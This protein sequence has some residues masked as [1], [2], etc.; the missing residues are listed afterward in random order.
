MASPSIV[1]GRKGSFGSVHWAPNGGFA[2]DTAYFIDRYTSSVNLRWLYYVL[3]AIDLKGPSQDVGVPGLARDAAYAVPV[4]SPPEAETQ[5]R[6]ADF[7]DAETR[8]TDS[9]SGAMER[10]IAVLDQHRSGALD[11][12]WP[13]E[14]KERRLGYATLLVTSGSRAWAD[15]VGDDGSP[16]FRSANLRRTS[17][18]PNATGLA[19]V[20]L[21]ASVAVEARRSRIRN[22][23]VL[24]GIT[25][26]NTGWVA[27]ADGTFVGGNVSQHVCLVRPD[28]HV[29]HSRWLAHL[30]CTR[31]VQ[32]YL[33]AGQYGGTKTQ[34]SL[35]DIRDVRVPVVPIAEQLRVSIQVDKALTSIETLKGA[36]LRQLRLLAERRQAL[37]T[38]A[39]TGQIDVSTARG[40]EVP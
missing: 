1:I 36:R 15:Y 14:A 8:R 5:R 2:I 30:L 20:A 4:P 10:Q 25:G 22:G 33:L 18:K 13:N 11:A 28:A 12:I 23:D 9:A 21:P 40:V 29:L 39:V 26:A 17:I 19:R 7:L 3:Q 32:D 27:L 16:F 31:T 24:I 37:I 34:L 38:A 35:P 6:I